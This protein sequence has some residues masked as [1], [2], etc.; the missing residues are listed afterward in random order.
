MSK[1]NNKQ[2]QA[3]AN[4]DNGAMRQALGKFPTGVTVVTT[5]AP[6]GEPVGFTA[7][8]FTSVSLKPPLVLICL[9]KIASLCE[10]FAAADSYAINILAADQEDLS[11]RFASR[12]GDRFNLV[13]WH[14]E[15]TGSPILEGT[16]AWLD[17]TLKEVIDGG[18]HLLLLGEVQSSAFTDAM[19]LG[20]YAG[21]YFSIRL[22]HDFLKPQNGDAALQSSSG[23]IIDADNTIFLIPQ[24]DGSYDVPRVQTHASGRAPKE[25]DVELTRL[26]LDVDDLV[27]FSVVEGRH[28]QRLAVYYRSALLKDRLGQRSLLEHGRFYPFDLIPWQ[29]LVSK[30]MRTM[31]ERYIEEKRQ[32]QFGVYM[33]NEE[34]ARLEYVVGQP[35]VKGPSKG[36]KE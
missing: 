29:A 27:L 5:T 10:V 32:G 26:G 25:L 28:L 21:S 7:N 1:Q 22:T 15:I 19:P 33:S 8:S 36:G 24:D 3:V 2:A 16:A 18:D 11:N 35:L 12:G 6:G 30:G 20:Y 17:C 14:A 13:D 31:L 9:A 4:A 23:V 34:G